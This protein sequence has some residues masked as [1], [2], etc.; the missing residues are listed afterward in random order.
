MIAMVNPTNPSNPVIMATVKRE[1]ARL[2]FAVETLEV[3]TPAA[4]DQAFE[5]LRRY[6]PDLLL[7]VPDNALISLSEQIVPR[8]LAERVPTVAT[9]QILA[10]VGALV[11]YGFLLQEA[12]GGARTYLKRILSGARPTDPPIQ[13]PPI[14]LP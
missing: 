6:R 2:G 11:T 3:P 1:A 9:S 8:A 14:F 4:L 12:G 10:G 7:I 5:E 13:Q